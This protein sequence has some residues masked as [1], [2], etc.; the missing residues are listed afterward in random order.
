MFGW[1]ANQTLGERNQ[2]EPLPLRAKEVL[3]VPKGNRRRRLG[4]ADPAIQKHLLKAVLSLPKPVLRAASGGRAVY[5]GGRT[6]DPRFQFLVH[7]A[8][9]YASIE[10]LP[11]DK[12][13]QTRAQQ[14]ALVAGKREPGVQLEDLTL[15]GPRGPIAARLYRGAEQDPEMALLI[16]AHGG[17]DS[18]E[19]FESCDAFCSILAR[20]GRAPV[21][22]VPCLPSPERRFQACFDDVLA[23]YRHGRDHADRFGAPQGHAAIA[24]DSI[25]GAFAAVLC[26]ELRRLGEPQPSLQLLLYPW[27]DLSSQSRSMTEYAEATLPGEHEPWTPDRFLGPEDDP[28]DPRIS[29]LMAQDLS[30]LAPAVVVTAGF[31]PLVDQGEAYAK[32]LRAAGSPLIYRC[33]DHLVHGFAAFTGVVPAADTACREIAGVVREGLQGRIPP[34]HH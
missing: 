4:M 28:A 25:G 9:H 30:G 6:L 17:E 33:Y 31:D 14:L 1:G 34:P 11:E 32:R 23:A 13:R 16:Y 5:V 20:C 24:G 29:P 22:A 21:L 10:G 18:E 12:A 3:L 19:A 15:E 26:Q 8:R 7:A 2:G 27:V